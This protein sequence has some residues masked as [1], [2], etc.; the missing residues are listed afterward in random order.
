MKSFYFAR[1]PGEAFDSVNTR[2]VKIKKHFYSSQ[3]ILYLLLNAKQQPFPG[4]SSNLVKRTSSQYISLVFH[5]TQQPRTFVYNIMKH[6]LASIKTW[7]FLIMNAL[8]SSAKTKQISC[9]N[10][11]TIYSR[12]HWPISCRLTFKVK[13]VYSPELLHNNAIVHCG[14][15]L[16]RRWRWFIPTVQSPPASMKSK[17]SVISTVLLM[18]F[19]T[20]KKYV[21]VS[22]FSPKKRCFYVVMKHN[23]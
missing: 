6:S 17:Q 10:K 4:S 13:N 8:K 20:E 21:C 18:F 3:S 16:L 11:D 12:C 23:E 5:Q 14:V 2:T 9:N 1:N 7:N 19:P 15:S 22:L